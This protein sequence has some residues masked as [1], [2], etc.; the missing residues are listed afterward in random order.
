MLYQS[1]RRDYET[2]PPEGMTI[3]HFTGPPNARP[4]NSKTIEL[5][6]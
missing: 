5:A 2:P 1:N 3:A 4:E 6:K